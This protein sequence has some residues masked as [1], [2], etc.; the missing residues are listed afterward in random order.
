VLDL[1]T[2]APMQCGTDLANPDMYCLVNTNSKNL[3]FASGAEAELRWQPSR[4]LF[5][6]G[7]YSF[8]RLWG[9]TSDVYQLTSQHIFAAKAVVPLLENVIRVSAQATYASPRSG[10]MLGETFVM[11]LG[12]SGTLSHFRYFA[13]VQNLLDSRT[14]VPVPTQADFTH[15]PIYG[16]TFWLELAANL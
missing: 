11:N 5:V 16:R 3:I 10:T 4:F 9:A 7:V 2:A 13:G 14:A 1:D 15:V 6:D 12:F 8:V